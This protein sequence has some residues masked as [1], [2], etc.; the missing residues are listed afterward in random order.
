MTIDKRFIPARKPPTIPAVRPATVA[1]V[2]GTDGSQ[3]TV[4]VHGQRVQMFMP[5]GSTPLAV[6]DLVMSRRVEPLSQLFLPV[7][8]TGV[9][10]VIAIWSGS[11]L[12][13][14]V[15][16]RLCDGG[17]GTPDLRDKFVAMAWEPWG[18]VG[19]EGGSNTRDRGHTH[20]ITSYSG[21]E[22]SHTHPTP[23]PIASNT[24]WSLFAG[25]DNI[26]Q[27]HTHTITPETL[28]DTTAHRHSYN[29]ETDYNEEIVDA[30]PPYYALCYIQ[31]ITAKLLVPIGGVV[32]WAGLTPDIPDGFEICDGDGG[33]PYLGYGFV[34]GAG[35]IPVG[36]EDYANDWWPE[37]ADHAHG[38]ALVEDTIH[39]H[40]FINHPG[41]YFDG[42]EVHGEFIIFGAAGGA[43]DPHLHGVNDILVL[44]GDPHNHTWQLPIG[45]DNQVDYENWPVYYK[46]LYIQRMS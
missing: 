21:Y 32:M 39:V 31:A 18:E 42:A 12:T 20:A 35:I 43:G 40:R 14:P 10:G 2:I 45:V 19:E 29:G 26:G 33:R 37:I 9:S 28:T 30:R 5:I 22:S 7:A 46:L 6:G 1:E 23:D 3:Y 34:I 27:P 41:G 24:G 8:D 4:V 16:W 11:V 38:S 15:G 13:I 17:Q 44:A 36:T 25:P